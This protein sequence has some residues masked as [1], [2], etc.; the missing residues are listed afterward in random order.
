MVAITVHT[1]VVSV[2][3]GVVDAVFDQRAYAVF[4]EVVA[5][6]FGI[7]ATISS[8]APQIAGIVPGDLWAN[9][10][11]VFFEVVAWISMMYRVS[12][13]TSAVIFNARTW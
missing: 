9:L 1:G 10:R 7:V 11:V 6:D 12:T 13:S 3:E 8:E 4:P 2:I 5:E